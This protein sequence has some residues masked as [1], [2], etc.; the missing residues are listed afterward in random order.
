MINKY[1]KILFAILASIA[2]IIWASVLIKTSFFILLLVP[3]VLI[4]FIIINSTLISH[5]KGNAIKITDNQFP[6][7]YEHFEFCCDTLE[8]NNIP[9]IYLKNG[10]GVFNAFAT[11]FLAK[12]YIVLYSS[13]VDAV[14][15]DPDALRFYIGHELGHIKR[16]HILKHG[17]LVICTWL[18]IIGKAYLRACE[19]TCDLHGLK[20]C[21]NPESALKAMSVLLSGPKRYATIDTKHFIK[22]VNHGNEFWMSLHEM[23]SSHPWISHRFETLDAISKNKKPKKKEKNIFAVLL[24]CLIP[25]I[26]NNLFINLFLVVYFVICLSGGLLLLTHSL[27]LHHH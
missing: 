5:L 15:E 3:I 16:K 11:R 27:G 22:Q 17:F 18:P 4:P 19:Y 26:S 20:C 25:S 14:Q 12:N 6:D 1:E 13:I 9:D 8:I 10:N 2:A 7:L 23:Q 24:S 21:E